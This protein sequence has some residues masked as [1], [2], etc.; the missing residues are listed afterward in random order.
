MPNWLVTING[1]YDH[2]ISSVS[3]GTGCARQS[4][5][6]DQVSGMIPELTFPFPKQHMCAQG[7]TTLQH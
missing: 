6:R 7:G 3:I 2:Y 4:R 1:Q 5:R